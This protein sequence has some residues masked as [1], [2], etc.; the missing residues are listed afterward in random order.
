[1]ITEVSWTNAIAKAG[2]AMVRDRY[3]KDRQWAKF[4]ELV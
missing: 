1:L 4:R 3:S 2:R